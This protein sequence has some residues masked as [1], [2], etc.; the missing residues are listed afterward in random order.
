MT[1]SEARRGL[2]PSWSVPVPIPEPELVDTA[3]G[4]RLRPWRTNAHD[5]AALV[6][7]WHDGSVMAANAV[8]QDA[9]P[10]AARRW[11]LGEADRRVRGLAL[12]L[13]I[14][15]LGEL[16]VAWRP[17]V[18]IARIPLFSNAGTGTEADGDCR[19]ADKAP[20]RSSV[21]GEVGMR[22]F[23]PVARRA[24]VGWWLAPHARGR[25]VAA[26]AVDLLVGWA[27]APPLDLRQVWAR[28]DPANEASARVARHAGFR[29]LGIAG[30]TAVWSRQ[31]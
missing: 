1:T 12:D 24:E 15:V 16:A 10:E 2:R 19:L 21:W 11:I 7:A 27:L 25:G 8:P 28:I 22:G 31:P 6:A 9:S 3:R 13:V 18:P 20:G 14:S 29:R 17:G 4:V 26:A 23:D 30:G 5:G